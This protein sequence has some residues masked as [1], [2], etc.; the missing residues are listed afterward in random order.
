MLKKLNHFL[1]LRSEKDKLHKL[2][3]LA[4][5]LSFDMFLTIKHIITITLSIEKNRYY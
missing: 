5:I 1:D 2:C 4:D 3:S